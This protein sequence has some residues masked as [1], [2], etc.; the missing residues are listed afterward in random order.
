MVFGEIGIDIDG[1]AIDGDIQVAGTEET[2][3]TT[4]L[5][6]Y[7]NLLISMVLSSS[8]LIFLYAS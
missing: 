6:A 7:S 1:V 4:R 3:S 8:A 2:S 5:S